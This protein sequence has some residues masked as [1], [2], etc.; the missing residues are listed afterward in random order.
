MA[1]GQVLVTVGTTKF[2]L[3]ISTVCS[4][5]V[6]RI[7]KRRGYKKLLLQIGNGNIPEVGCIEGMDVEYFRF[8]DSIIQDI[9]DSSLVLSHAGAGSCLEVLGAKKPLVVV[10]NEM[11][12]NNHQIELAKQLFAKEH[13]Y[14]CTCSELKE[15]LVHMNVNSLKPFPSGKPENFA[16]FLNEIFGF[17]DTFGIS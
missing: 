9:Q 1:T 6:S 7:L 2:D 4:A 8:K 16:N 14:Y 17:N 5:E 11:L 3:F 12:M 10:V 15:T 13:A